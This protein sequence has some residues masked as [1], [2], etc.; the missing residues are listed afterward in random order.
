MIYVILRTGQISEMDVARVM[1]KR[2]SHAFT[3]A[4]SI[5]SGPP[6]LS[7]LPPAVIAVQGCGRKR[8]H[9]DAEDLEDGESGSSTKRRNLEQVSDFANRSPN[10]LFDETIWANQEPFSPVRLTLA[11]RPNFTTK[12]ALKSIA[13]DLLPQN[14]LPE[15]SRQ[16]VQ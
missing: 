11:S 6:S 8:S 13:P 16:A 4:G 12:S 10:Q 9:S 3:R 7:F 1:R 15:R 14:D 5:A 2:G